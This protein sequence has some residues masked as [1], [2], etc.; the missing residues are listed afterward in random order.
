MSFLRHVGKIGDRKVAIVFREVPNETHMCLV[1][2]TDTL[3]RHIHDPMMKC[4]ESDIGQSSQ[5]LADALNRT[6]TQDGK[7][8]LQVLHSQ[9]MLK[10]VQTE[11]V[12]VTPNSNT[13]IKLSDLNKILDE[14]EQGEAAVRR[15][16]EI[17]SSRGIQDAN[18]VA[19]RARDRAA[20][21]SLP[22]VTKAEDG[23]LSDTLIAKNLRTQA[24]KM[25][26]EARGLLAESARLQTEASSLD[27]VASMY[28]SPNASN[29][30]V[31]PVAKKRGRPAKVKVPV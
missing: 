19:Q 17:D 24:S 25:E 30:P 31:A 2:F 10:K 18:Q 23:L 4:I 14:M 15:L 27:G 11:T 13:R 20:E 29:V 22:P 1:A 3:N 28:A 16:A 7:Y 12:V 21:S 26:A 8:I 9:G 5:N 6:H